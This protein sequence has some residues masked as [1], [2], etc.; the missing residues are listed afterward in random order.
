M[1]GHDPIRVSPARP[2][3]DFGRRLKKNPHAQVCGF[4]LSSLFAR[5]LQLF[6]IHIVIKDRIIVKML[7]HGCGKRPCRR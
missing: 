7:L 6:S 3:R 1:Y 2:L 4:F 5:V